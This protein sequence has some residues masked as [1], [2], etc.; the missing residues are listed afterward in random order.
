MAS[1]DS[2]VIQS[3][4]A[5]QAE[6]RKLPRPEEPRTVKSLARW[7]GK[8]FGCR[9]LHW[10]PDLENVRVEVIV[11]GQPASLSVYGPLDRRCGSR[12][13]VFFDKLFKVKY[14]APGQSGAGPVRE[15]Q[16]GITY[17]D[18][19][20]KRELKPLLDAFKKCAT[21]AGALIAS[22]KERLACELPAETLATKQDLHRWIFAVYDIAWRQP[23]GSPLRATRYIP[24]QGLDAGMQ[25]DESILYDIEHLRAT[26]WT[27]VER[28]LDPNRWGSAVNFKEPYASW[29]VE[30]PE[31]YASRIDDIAQSSDWAIDWLVERLQKQP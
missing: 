1:D 4:A 29:G 28:R 19:R 18:S 31:Y 2:A 22:A 8:I 9:L 26:P 5:I 12:P 6:L 27:A 15:R 7:A 21:Q 24:V 13:H 14:T 23:P 11:Q 10:N 25:T 16:F 3:F 17:S 20:P 30:L